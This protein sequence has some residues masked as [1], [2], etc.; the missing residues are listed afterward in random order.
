MHLSLT[1]FNTASINSTTEATTKVIIKLLPTPVPFLTDWT[2]YNKYLR[3]DMGA[4]EM[5]AC[6]GMF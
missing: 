1:A 4:G 2:Q 5:G 6:G 3:M